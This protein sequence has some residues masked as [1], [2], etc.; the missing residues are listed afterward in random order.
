[1]A[2][3]AV[4]DHHLAAFGAGDTDE[5]LADYT[6]QSVLITA[7]G[8]IRGLD[9]LREAFDGF[10]GGLFAPGTYDLVMDAVTVE[11]EVAYVVWHADCASADVSL[12]TDTFLM[13]E[14]KIAVHTFTATI[15]PK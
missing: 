1:M 15:N 12:G 13:R 11:G 5:I 10:L 7:D 9:A 14:G 8:T 3:Q 6:D 2:T 4:L